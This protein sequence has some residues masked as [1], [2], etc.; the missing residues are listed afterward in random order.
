MKILI[1]S[2]NQKTI[3]LLTKY[4]GFNQVQEHNI[5]A[6]TNKDDIE[7]LTEVYDFDLI[8]SEGFEKY[9]ADMD[10]ETIRLVSRKGRST[11]SKLED[12][13]I[14]KPVSLQ[15]V[16]SVVVATQLAMAA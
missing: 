13:Y 16:K 11:L 12:S 5:F 9:L 3:D 7:L 4:L 2:Q 1:I 10:V 14:T 8:F 6:A 15:D